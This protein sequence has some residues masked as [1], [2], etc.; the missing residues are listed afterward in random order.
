MELDEIGNCSVIDYNYGDGLNEAEDI[1]G[2]GS[3][4]LGADD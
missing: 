3:C 2:G 1:D 4:L